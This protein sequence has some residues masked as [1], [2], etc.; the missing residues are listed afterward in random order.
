MA[1]QANIN[2]KKIHWHHS[3]KTVLIHNTQ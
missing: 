1:F 2:K 3:M